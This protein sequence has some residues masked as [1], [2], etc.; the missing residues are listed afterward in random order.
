MDTD[1]IFH[2]LVKHEQNL[3]KIKDKNYDLEQEVL[4]L[5]DEVRDLEFNTGEVHLYYQ[6]KIIKLEEK[7]KAWDDLEALVESTSGNKKFTE[8]FYNSEN[9]CHFLAGNEGMHNDGKT[10]AEAV[11]NALESIR[12]ES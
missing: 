4:R 10:L 12:G 6:N 2:E 11:S 7:A 8:L 3:V 1:A 9:Q 5:K